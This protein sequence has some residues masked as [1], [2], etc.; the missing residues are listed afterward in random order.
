[1]KRII[2]PVDF[3]ETANNAV[4]Y[5][6]NL[7]NYLKAELTLFHVVHEPSLE[8]V[9]AVAGGID[10]GGKKEFVA[11]ERLETYCDMVKDNFAI[12]CRPK[13]GSYTPSMEASLRNEIE[14]KKYD[15]VVM[16]TDGNSDISQFFLGTHTNHIIGKISLPILVVPFGCPFKKIE[17]VV[18][19]SNYKVEDIPALSSVMMLMQVF[20]PQL[21]LLHVNKKRTKND[22]EVRLLLQDVYQDKLKNEKLAFDQVHSENVASAIDNYV[23]K[24]NADLLVLVTHKYS[25]IQD[26]FHDSITKKMSLVADYPILI[27]HVSPIG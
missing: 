11:L 21:T 20:N 26:I 13:V 25:W 24:N 2:C 3:S 8:D 7:A 1:M 16:G 6:A 9:S 5:A 23:T 22:K 12:Q 27:Q 17:N 4:E 18:Y 19:A 15:L 14:S 10:V